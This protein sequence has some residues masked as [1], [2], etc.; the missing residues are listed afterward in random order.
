MRIGSLFE[1]LGIKILALV[2]ALGLYAH[3]ATE[4]PVERV[5]Y[6]PLRLEGLA[7]SLAFGT[8]A[9]ERV[10]ARLRGTGKQVIRLTVM[11]PPVEVRLDGVRAGQYQRALTTADFKRVSAE[12]VEVLGLAEPATLNLTIEPRAAVRLP[13]A[14]RLRGAPARGFVLSGPPLASPAQVKISGPRSWVRECDSIATQPVPVAGKRDTVELLLPLV[15]PPPWAVAEPGSVL[16]QVPIEPETSGVRDLV[17][18][19]KG[20]RS[21]FMARLDPPRVRVALAVPRSR[22]GVERDLRAGVDLGRRGRG[23]YVLPVRL[24]GAGAAYVRSVQPESVA[25]TVH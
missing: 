15:A 8:S 23:R 10:G 14:V 4:Q 19:V 22:A 3:V 6:F 9:P 7:D 11:R 1:N 12:G 24:S 13:V 20:L 16:V 25:V 21:A 18:E 17:P 5:M 2:F